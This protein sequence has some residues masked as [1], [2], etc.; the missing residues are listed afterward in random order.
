MKSI[1]EVF[2]LTIMIVSLAVQSWEDLRH[3]L[4]YDEASLLLAVAGL[5]HSFYFGQLL[6][7][8]FACVVA[9]ATMGVLYF[10]SRGGMGL[11]DV[12]LAAA[13]AT[14]LTPVTVVLMLVLAFSL[15]GV[16]AAI[17]ICFGK[18][19][20]YAMP[21]GPFLAMAFLFAFFY[22]RQILDFY[23]RML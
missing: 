11:G 3:K 13:C 8:I 4:L 10:C 19:R 22:G 7:G 18:S 15:G 2:L 6:D 23:F 9:L 1:L 12:F 5:T 14:W 21:F 16:L 20:K 17:F